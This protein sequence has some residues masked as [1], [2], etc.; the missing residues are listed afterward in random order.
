MSGEVIKSVLASHFKK[1]RHCQCAYEAMQQSFYEDDFV[2]QTKDTYHRHCK[3]IEKAPTEQHKNDLKVTY[4]INH[5]SPLCDLDNFDITRQLPQDIM[6]T[7][8]EGVV[9]YE[10]RYILTHY[11]NNGQFTLVDLNAAISSQNYGYSEVSNKP[12][13]LRE[14]VFQGE[15]GYKLKYKAAQARLFLR[16]IPFI[17]CLL[18]PLD[19]DYYT[20]ITQLIELCQIVFSQ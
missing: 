12:R 10:L 7:L 6:H 9:Q 15:G 2:P 11:I 5:R 13:P 19:D 20:V 16:L 1:C 8:L 18:I 3:E 14:S 4:G 17:L